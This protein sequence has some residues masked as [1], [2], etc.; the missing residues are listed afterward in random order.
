MKSNMVT[1]PI[2]DQALSLPVD[3]DSNF[4][5]RDEENYKGALKVTRIKNRRYV[6]MPNFPKRAVAILKNWLHDH[7]DNPYP[8]H[9]EKEVLSKESGLSKR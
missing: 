2:S 1:T 9:K 7:L 5:E 3:T 6:R 8:T 4:D